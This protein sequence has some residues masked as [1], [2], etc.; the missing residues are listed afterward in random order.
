M[1]DRDSDPGSW[2]KAI[3]D[4]PTI[5]TNRCPVE[6]CDWP[7]GTQCPLDICPGSSKRREVA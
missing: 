3:H 1:I 7:E 5:N 2:A 4:T 6:G